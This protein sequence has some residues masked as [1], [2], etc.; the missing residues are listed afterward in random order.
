[1]PSSQFLRAYDNTQRIIIRVVML[2]IE[3]GS[4]D[5]EVDFQIMDILMTF[6]LLLGRPWLHPNDAIAS[7][8]YQKGK[9]I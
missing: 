9:F 5:D 2:K 1:M 8:L 4:L 7:T 3:V 6:N